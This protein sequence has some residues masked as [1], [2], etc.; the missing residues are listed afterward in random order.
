MLIGLIQVTKDKEVKE[1]LLKGKKLAEKQV[2]TLNKVLKSEEHLGNLPV[3]MEVT[4][5][6]VSPFYDKLLMFL[7]TTTTA[8]GNYLLSYTMSTSLR[9]DLAAHYAIFM[10]EVANFGGEGLEIMIKRGWMEQPPQSVDRS[11]Y[12]KN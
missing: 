4:T 2:E 3:S 6:T 8:T 11:S 10:A 12:Y 5:S 7:I 9:K 1:F